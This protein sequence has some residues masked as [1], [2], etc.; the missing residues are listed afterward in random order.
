MLPSVIYVVLESPVMSKRYWLIRGHDC[1]E[2]FAHKAGLG[3]FS[4]RQI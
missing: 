3:E 1:D 4:D 2:P